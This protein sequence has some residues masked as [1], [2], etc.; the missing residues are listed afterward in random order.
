MRSIGNGRIVSSNAQALSSW[1]QDVAS[2]ALANRPSDWPLDAAYS[3]KCV[4]RFQRPQS[5]F[6]KKGLRPSAPKHHT[7]RPDLDKLLRAIGDAISVTGALMR[8]DALICRQAQ[9]K[10]YCEPSQDP[11]VLI[12]IEVLP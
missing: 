11:G 9:E 5:H 7:K 4:F 3:L 2:I 8:D 12:A 1:R 6:G 10:I